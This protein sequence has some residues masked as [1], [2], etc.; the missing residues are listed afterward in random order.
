MSA[1]VGDK[2]ER[3]FRVT[4]SRIRFRNNAGLSVDL[5]QVVGQAAVEALHGLLLVGAVAMQ[6]VQLK[7]DWPVQILADGG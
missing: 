7:A 1:P 4:A 5:V 3:V 2:E 6:S